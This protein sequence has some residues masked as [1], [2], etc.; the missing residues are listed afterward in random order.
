MHTHYIKITVETGKI[1]DTEAH[2]EVTVLQRSDSSEA[3]IRMQQAITRA[4]TET[5]IGMGDE[6]IA[7]G[8]D[9]EVKGNPGAIR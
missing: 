6:K 4:L 8:N 7:R 9:P 1:D 5:F 3:T 2:Q